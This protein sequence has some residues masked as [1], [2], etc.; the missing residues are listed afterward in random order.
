MRVM[1]FTIAEITKVVVNVL[2]EGV[3]GRVIWVWR[4]IERER[5]RIY[6]IGQ[7]TIL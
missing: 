1:N 6:K 2:E 3:V 4:F 5:E 7:R